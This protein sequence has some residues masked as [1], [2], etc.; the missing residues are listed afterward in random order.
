MNSI[1]EIIEVERFGKALAHDGDDRQAALINAFAAELR[2]ACRG[3][4]RKTEMQLCYLS[5]R[6][7]VHGE[8]LVIALADFTK[9]RRETPV[10]LPPQEEG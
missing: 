3:D 1:L 10:T 7:T 5:D 6:L 9:L 8:D 4:E 2:V